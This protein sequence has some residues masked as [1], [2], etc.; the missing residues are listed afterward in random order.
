MVKTV[1]PTLVGS[2]APAFSL[3]DDRCPPRVPYGE[4]PF[5]EDRTRVVLNA[6]SAQGQVGAALMDIDV[7][8]Y[9]GCLTQ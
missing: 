9:R 1:D 3:A 6:S 8:V 2:L 7:V 4:H 5:F